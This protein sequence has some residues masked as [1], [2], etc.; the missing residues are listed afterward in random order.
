MARGILF[1]LFTF[2]SPEDKGTLIRPH[3]REMYPLPMSGKSIV[4][5]TGEGR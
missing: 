4:K 2:D 3:G 1:F 5:T